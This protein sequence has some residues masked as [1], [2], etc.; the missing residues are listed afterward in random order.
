MTAP[1][2]EVASEVKK[3]KCFDNT[4]CVIC[5]SQSSEVFVS[6]P[7]DSSYNKLVQC[8]LNRSEW[9][10]EKCCLIRNY[11]VTEEFSVNSLK[12]KNGKWHR[13]CYLLITLKQVYDKLQKKF[14]EN[15][16]KKEKEQEQEGKK[17]PGHSKEQANTMC[18]NATLCKV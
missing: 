12:A 13:S 18:S 10:D 17:E 14:T 3:K 15:I 6:N 2:S 1:S 16:Q 9:G 5:Q 11:F 8:I 7:S 4:L